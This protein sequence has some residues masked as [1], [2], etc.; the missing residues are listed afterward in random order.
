M[1]KIITAN[2]SLEVCILWGDLIFYSVG[3]GIYSHIYM[4][5]YQISKLRISTFS[6]VLF[7]GMTY[8]LKWKNLFHQSCKRNSTKNSQPMLIKRLN[9]NKENSDILESLPVHGLASSPRVI[10][11]LLLHRFLLQNKLYHS[12]W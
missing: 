9:S 6:E 10:T 4:L 8:T 11:R 12:L 5:D 3:E 1:Y 2:L 7:L